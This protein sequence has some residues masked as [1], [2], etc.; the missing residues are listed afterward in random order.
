MA[1]GT[2]APSLVWLREA[3]GIPRIR[4][5]QDWLP[6]SFKA[7]IPGSRRETEMKEARTTSSRGTLLKHLGAQPCLAREMWQYGCQLP[8]SHQK[9]GVLSLAEMGGEWVLGAQSL[10]SLGKKARTLPCE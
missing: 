1:L 9:A 2:Q 5:T 8:M 3:P 10:P 6:L 4:V 7:S